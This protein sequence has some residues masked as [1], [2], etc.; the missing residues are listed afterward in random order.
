VPY[1]DTIKPLETMMTPYQT[2]RSGIILTALFT[3][4]LLP[5][6]VSAAEEPNWGSGHGMTWGG[7]IRHWFEWGTSEH[8]CGAEGKRNIDRTITLIDH[9][10]V[11]TEAQK[12][13]EA[14]LKVALLSAQEQ[15]V[16][17]CEKPHSGRWSPVERLNT[18]ETH[19]SAMLNAIHVIKAPL[20]TF[21]DGLSE[22]Q[23]AKLDALHPDWRMNIL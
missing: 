2:A 15:L 8:F 13:S 14:A 18:S 23:K 10:I 5:A 6:S 20:E 17:I 21:Y 11:P 16:S 9:L 3:L 12:P 1:G 19:L 7:A 22:P 4:L